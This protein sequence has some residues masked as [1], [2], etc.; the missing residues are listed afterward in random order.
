MRATYLCYRLELFTPIIIMAQGVY[1]LILVQMEWYPRPC[2]PVQ[3]SMFFNP[4]IVCCCTSFVCLS[5][6]ISKIVLLFLIRHIVG[7]TRHNYQNAAVIFYRN[8]SSL[9][10]RVVISYILFA[11]REILP[12]L[13]LIDFYHIPT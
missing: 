9:R 11:L 4:A 12:I 6:L 5:Y 3:F 2:N 10:A 1:F 8:H 7:D 13:S